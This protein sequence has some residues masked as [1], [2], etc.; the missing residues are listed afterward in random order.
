MGSMPAMRRLALVVLVIGD[1]FHP[2][3]IFAVCRPGDSQMG[4][5]G[6]GRGAMPML[7]AWRAPHHVSKPDFLHRLA[8]FLS[9]THARDDHQALPR[10]MRV[11]GG[12][13]SGLERDQ[14]TG[15]A[16]AVIRWPDHVYA[17]L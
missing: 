5:C 6:V 10:R 3:N 12:A 1:F 14:R 15:C 11:P 9:E 13:R 4:H 17:N 8:P 7:D 16:D 2:F